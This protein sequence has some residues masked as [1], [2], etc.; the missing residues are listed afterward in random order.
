M[1]VYMLN[2]LLKTIEIQTFK[3]YDIIVSDHS[4]SDII[5]KECENWSHLDIKYYKNSSGKGSAAMNLNFA[6]SKAKGEYIKTIFQDDYFH[7]PKALEYYMN[8]IE[9]Y[10]WAVAG[11]FHCNENNTK[12]LNKPHSPVW[13]EPEKMLSGINKISGP[14][15]MLFKND[16][17]YFN[18]DL[19]WLNDV[20]FY[21]RLF[22]KYNIPLLLP[23]KIIVQRLRGEG[24]SNTLNSKIKIEE[25]KY[26]L[27]K[28]GI[29]KES[30]NISDYPMMFERI[31]K[32]K[33]ET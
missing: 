15:V 18:E 32:L 33:N 20:E 19:C 21:Y 30:K 9:E 14:S 5:E 17:N 12:N 23:K 10:G 27:A 1:G 31:K 4:S 7:S 25:S 8:N 13:I 6:I 28:H 26:V 29:S 11:T 22:K 2:F 16:N 3:D 24:V